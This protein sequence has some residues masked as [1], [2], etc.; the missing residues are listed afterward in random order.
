MLSRRYSKTV[1][2][3]SQSYGLVSL[4]STVMSAAIAEAGWANGCA[5][6]EKTDPG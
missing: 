3:A 2:R 1:R 5:R 6:H 4:V